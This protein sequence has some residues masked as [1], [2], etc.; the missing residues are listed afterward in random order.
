M[1]LYRGTYYTILDKVARVSEAYTKEDKIV[2][3]FSTRSFSRDQF[4]E[5][6]PR[7]LRD[8]LLYSREFALVAHLV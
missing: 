4:L 6:G 1:S 5:V 3:E 2:L 7:G 8:I